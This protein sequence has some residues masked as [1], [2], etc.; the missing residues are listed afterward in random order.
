MKSKLILT[1]SLEE[2]IKG[3]DIVYGT[4]LDN[5]EDKLHYVSH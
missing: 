2:L 4:M 3:Q 5:N 1:D